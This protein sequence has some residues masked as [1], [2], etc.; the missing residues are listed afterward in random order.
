MNFH[1]RWSADDCTVDVPPH[2]I[3]SHPL[4]HKILEEVGMTKYGPV[5]AGRGQ[6]FLMDAWMKCQRQCTCVFVVIEWFQQGL[7]L[8]CC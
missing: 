1:G 8:L 3:K 7:W 6:R 2:C 4:R 5:V